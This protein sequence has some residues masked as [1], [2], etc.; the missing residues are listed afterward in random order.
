ML[1]VRDV[2]LLFVLLRAACV[3]M[4]MWLCGVYVDGD[5]DV[6]VCVGCA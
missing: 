1:L 3:L 4:V 5:T 2:P 6:C